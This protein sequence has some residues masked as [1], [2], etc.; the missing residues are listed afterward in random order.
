MLRAAPRYVARVTREALRTRLR[1]ERRRLPPD[2]VAA[3]SARLAAHVAD[4]PWVRGAGVL[5]AYQGVG[6]EPELSAWLDP[7]RHV[8][9]L[10]RT[11]DRR[12]VLHRWSGGPLVPGVF[13]IPEPPP[14]LPV[15]A[16][17]DVDVWLVPGVAFDRRGN[18]IGHGAGCYDRVLAGTP[19]RKIGVAWAFQVVDALTCEPHDVPMDAIVT[20]EGWI[21]LGR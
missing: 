12:I 5:A 6:G 9:A 8:L 3:R 2:E 13:R 21:P 19:G 1:A 7:A 20:E 17:H 18:R 10:P 11:V 15:V 4:H 14:D 16:P